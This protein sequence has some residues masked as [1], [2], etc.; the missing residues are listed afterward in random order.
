MKT[1][2]VHHPGCQ[3]WDEFASYTSSQ[4]GNER[5]KLM[6]KLVQ[7]TGVYFADLNPK[8]CDN[9]NNLKLTL[10]VSTISRC[11]I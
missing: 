2:G 6:S 3:V 9:L 7:F 4:G 5:R 8:S 1:E 10:N 11:Q